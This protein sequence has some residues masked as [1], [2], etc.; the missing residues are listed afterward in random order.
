MSRA[1]REYEALP[2]S[3]GDKPETTIPPF[4]DPIGSAASTAHSPPSPRR[5]RH[6]YHRSLSSAELD[7]AQYQN[8]RFAEED[9]E[10]PESPPQRRGGPHGLGITTGSGGTAIPRR[11]VGATDSRKSPRT[12]RSAESLQTP[13]SG[14][15]AR[16]G[17]PSSYKST[18][19]LRPSRTPQDSISSLQAPFLSN[20]ELYTLKRST[21][22]TPEPGNEG[23][24]GKSQVPSTHH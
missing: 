13:F 22:T 7:I 3:T 20:T 1:H 17:Y 21:N 10:V 8:V 19:P 4:S 6:T 24:G 11:P 5:P 12:P 16:A 9:E 18:D 15:T 14:T 23:D 2:G